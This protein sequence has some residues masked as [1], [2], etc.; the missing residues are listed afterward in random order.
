[1]GIVNKSLNIPKIKNGSK[2]MIG[3]HDRQYVLF[4]DH[5]FNWFQ[6]MMMKICFGF[7]V[8]DY[9]EE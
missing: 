8:E 6:K 1:M 5:H 4:V 2:I 7:I 3:Q 9:E